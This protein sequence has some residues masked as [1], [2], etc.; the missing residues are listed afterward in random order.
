MFEASRFQRAYPRLATVCRC[1][2]TFSILWFEFASSHDP[3]ELR[4]E[5]HVRQYSTTNAIP[6]SSI[7]KLPMS[8][9]LPPAADEKEVAP[10]KTMI[11]Q[12]IS[13]I[14]RAMD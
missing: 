3:V 2:S 12:A 7:N 1:Q 8:L 11:E 14:V 9:A 10:A 4:F 6:P 5:F 13:L